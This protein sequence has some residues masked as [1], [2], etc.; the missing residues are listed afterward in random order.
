MAWARMT[1]GTRQMA[2]GGQRTHEMTDNVQPAG[3]KVRLAV[4]KTGLLHFQ[5]LYS[6]DFCPKPAPF[7]DTMDTFEPDKGGGDENEME[8]GMEEEASGSGLDI[9]KKCFAE[10]VCNRYL[11]YLYYPDLRTK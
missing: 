8:M 2:S 10:E 6:R 5:H 9:R 7:T 1:S 11:Y 4:V 3:D